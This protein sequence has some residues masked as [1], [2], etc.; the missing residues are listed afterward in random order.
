MA[1]H[2]M[3]DLE[4]LSTAADAAILQIG[5]QAFDPRGDGI[6][7]A[8]GLI[9]HVSGEASLNAGLRMDWQTIQW[10][11]SL[12]DNARAG[13][14]AKQA[15]ALLLSEALV[16]LVKFGQ[17]HGGW[18]WAKVWSNGA[19]FDIPILETAFRR[20]RRDIPW[21]YNNVL[22]VRTMKWL[23]PDV[24]RVTPDVAHDALSDAQAQ[25]VYVQRCYKAIKAAPEPAPVPWRP[26]HRHVKRGSEYEVIARAE[27]QNSGGLPIREGD[28]LVIYQG[29][30]GDTWARPIGEFQDGRFEE[31]G[32]AKGAPAGE[33]EPQEPH[34]AATE[35]IVEAGEEDKTEALA[36]LWDR[37]RGLDW[38]YMMSEDP[39]VYKRGSAAESEARAAANG[40]G[41]AGKALYAA[42]EEHV[43]RG[44]PEVPRPGA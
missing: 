35:T 38:W 16:E 12:D 17:S 32:A 40:L 28:L 7:P 15:D 30:I 9:I 14:V 11:L 4:T 18:A 43:K 3:I 26:T 19:A 2:F 31:L 24:P 39:G 6:D 37:L 8:Q 33:E 44:G 1:N 13:M 36:A 21:A 42:W 20:C 27:V 41:D 23:A 34:A 29:D 10:W 22:D 25:A 5:I